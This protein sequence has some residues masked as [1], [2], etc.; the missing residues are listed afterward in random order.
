MKNIIN[1]ITYLKNIIIDIFK[2]I[3]KKFELKSKNLK[4][5]EKFDNGLSE[6]IKIYDYKAL[7]YLMIPKRIA[8]EL[9]TYLLLKGSINYKNGKYNV[10]KT[11]FK[12]AKKGFNKNKNISGICLASLGLGDILYIQEKYKKAQ[13]IY[14]KINKKNMKINDKEVEALVLFH[15]GLLF[16]LTAEFDKSNT[17]LLKAI[18]IFEKNSHFIGQGHCNYELARNYLL[19]RDKIKAEEYYNKANK[20]FSSIK[21]L[22]TIKDTMFFDN[23]YKVPDT[24]Y[25]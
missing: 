18:D 2:V 21:G 25:L 20:L 7:Q 16:Q 6:F 14:D 17:Y 22:I 5:N 4:N 8:K 12:K 24:E 23:G 19:K 9:P 3:N 11:Y 13:K 15:Y 1:I 10:A